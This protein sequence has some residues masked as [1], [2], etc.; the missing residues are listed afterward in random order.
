MQKTNSSKRKFKLFFFINLKSILNNNKLNNFS[1][2]NKNIMVI[3]YE[4]NL[5]LF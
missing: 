5:D 1:F 2:K 4:I 3:I